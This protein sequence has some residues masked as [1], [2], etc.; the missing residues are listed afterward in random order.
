MFLLYEFSLM[1]IQNSSRLT[2]NLHPFAVAIL[3]AR[4]IFLSHPRHPHTALRGVLNFDPLGPR[5]LLR[6]SSLGV[7]FYEL[8]GLLGD[9]GDSAVFAFGDRV[10]FAQNEPESGLKLKSTRRKP[11]QNPRQP[12][13]K[14]T[15]ALTHSARSLLA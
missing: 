14:I 10:R 3:A 15:R 8:G 12:V 11:P 9:W 7:K 1:L 5:A 2:L 4:R 13:M 6:T